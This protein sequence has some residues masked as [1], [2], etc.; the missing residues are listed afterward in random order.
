VADQLESTSKFL[1]YVLRHQPD[2]IGLTLDEEGWADLSELIRLANADGRDLTLEL[3]KQVVATN[4][5]KRF[6]LSDDGS[7]IR[8]SQGHSVAIELGLTP[9]TPPDVLYHGTATR[10]LDSIREKGLI[11]GSRRHVHLSAEMAT[12]AD[13]GRRHGKPTVLTIKSSEMHRLGHE[14]F[15]SENGVWL[16]PAVPV[17]FLIFEDV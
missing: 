16:T 14:F 9:V 11:S 2:S 3:I 8:A 1:S 15:I 12:A 5:K 17:D 4:D 10:F 13:V 7:R 6:A